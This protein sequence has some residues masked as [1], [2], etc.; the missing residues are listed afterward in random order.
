MIRR[1]LTIRSRQTVRRA[2]DD[3]VR[4]HIE[5][6]AEALMRS[7][8]YTSLD[9]AR[10][11]AIREFGNVAEAR[12]ELTAMDERA[13]GRAAR[14]DW[15]RD[16]VQDAR[17]ALRDFRR[18]PA[19]TG[20][21]VAILALGI[22]SNAA[23]FSLI[24]AVRLRPLPVPQP[25]RLV[26]LGSN[27]M[28]GAIGSSSTVVGTVFTYPSYRELRDR[29]PW[30][31]GLVASGITG[32][33]DVVPN[34][35]ATEPEHPSGRFVS[36]NYFQVLG[37]PAALGRT[38]DGSEDASVGASPVVVLSHGYWMRRFAGDSSVIG[39]AMTIDRV[40]FN[41]IGIAREGFFGEIVGEAPDLWVPIT[42]QPAMMP[43][44]PRLDAR[45]LYWLQLFGRMKPGVT[46]PQ[47]VERSKAVIRQVLEETVRADPAKTQMP[48]DLEI[49]VG[50]A[51]TGFSA[52][53]EDFATPLVTMMVGVTLVLLIVCANVGNLLL[54]RAVARSREMA[55]RM[56][57]G[58]GRP[59][60]V[61]QLLTESTVLALI[62]GGASLVVARWGSQLLL[63]FASSGGIG[64][65]LDVGLDPRVTLFT[66]S[67][68]LAA[69]ML[70][71]LAPAYR[72]TRVDVAPVLRAQ[73]RGSLGGGASAPG[74]RRS[75]TKTLVVGQVT[76]SLVLLV[77]AAML[78]RSLREL[79]RSSPGFDREH[80]LVVDV[81]DQA[82]GYSGARHLAFVREVRA[83]IAALPGV[84]GVSFSMNGLFSGSDWS[85]GITVPGFVPRTRQD[86]I[87][88]YD[89]AGP[90]YVRVIGARLI[91]GREFTERD[92]E[93]SAPVVL[94]NEAFARYY[95]RDADPLGR[96]LTF[97][98]SVDAPIQAQIV[99]VVSDTRTGE[100]S[101]R[102]GARSLT[103]PPVPRFY[104]SYLQ[105]PGE[106]PPSEA[107]FEIRVDGDPTLLID[108]VRRTIA[109]VDAQVPINNVY[110]L[111]ARIRDSIARERLV[112]KL[113]SGFGAVAL[114]LAAIG[115]YGLMM[116][117]VSRRT[118][119]LGLR[120]AL[121]A[122]RR[123][124][125]TMV[126]GEALRLVGAGLAIGI[127]A[128]YV[129]TRLIRSQVPG[130]G[131]IDVPSIAVAFG[132]LVTA[133][134]VA[135]LVPAIRAGRVA[136]IVALQQE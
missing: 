109:A 23:I 80:L 96:T 107:R 116:H 12:D 113:C 129:A 99:G 103:Q 47:A 119:E 87:V 105:H 85:T 58:A 53:R 32:R 123:D 61:R 36:G 94:V 1:I 101:W 124:I 86:S 10:A 46:L 108:P 38:F 18:H 31:T 91:K 84:T 63:A 34:A 3:E 44:E 69:V 67:I 55:V 22:G 79:E 33:L 125:V 9:D 6:R 100:T 106:V 50:S 13:A 97:T 25:E 42:M 77:G 41:V 127:P 64:A 52:V 59:R 128:G 16:L 57:I 89:Y 39:H 126:L 5:M 130:V 43:S 111:D 49:V 8:G 26:M 112:A 35:Q 75:L 74:R 82:V 115:L 88:R 37:V 21:L 14:A 66:A 81:D 60:L 72:A 132:V 110:A 118:G 65:T 136:P 121:G 134:V 135:A 98:D 28:T 56:A 20:A 73:G 131:A 122:E 45:Q 71:G 24:N 90:D 30:F 15:R 27:S 29:T 83:R 54:A 68:S 62:A 17:Y 133:A 51:A 78:V 114:V 95:F 19:F 117:T 70:F 120:M 93:G 7:G 2:V 92:V 11:Q 4:F 48:R 104:L 102:E 40:A 76:L